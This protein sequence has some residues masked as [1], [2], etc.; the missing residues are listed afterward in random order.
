MPKGKDL[1]RVSRAEILAGNTFG[2]LTNE[3]LTQDE[4]IA[5]LLS[6]IPVA[7][8]IEQEA[9]ETIVR[10]NEEIERLKNGKD[11]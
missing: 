1:G 9:R 4:K 6:L 3:Q 11:H 8:Q 10:L 7:L 5:S 2:I